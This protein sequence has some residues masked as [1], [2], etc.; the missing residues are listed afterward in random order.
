MGAP[1]KIAVAGAT[2]RVGRHV[3]DVLEERGHEAVAMSRSTGIDVVTGEGLAEAL[4]GADAIIDAA[5]PASRDEEAATAFFTA[6]ARNL[7]RGRTRRG[8]EPDR[9]RLDHRHRPLRGRLPGREAGAG[10]RADWP[11]RCRYRCCARRSSTSSSRS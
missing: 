6:S 5:T 3:V 8:R 10:A 11:A 4:A 7:Q 1:Q 9:G 2:G